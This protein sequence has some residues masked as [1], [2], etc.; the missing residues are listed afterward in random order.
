MQKI[1][2]WKELKKTP[3]LQDVGHLT[4]SV[5]VPI[6]INDNVDTCIKCLTNT[7]FMQNGG[8]L[9]ID[10]NLGGTPTR[11]LCI[12]NKQDTDFLVYEYPYLVR[13]KREFKRYKLGKIPTNSI[14]NIDEVVANINDLLARSEIL[15]EQE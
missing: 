6:T 5:S 8:E 9:Y 15:S 10:K 1:A 7:E 13:L 12:K 11:L 14:M 2:I 4:L 3:N